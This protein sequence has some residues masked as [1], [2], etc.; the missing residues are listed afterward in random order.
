MAHGSYL[1]KLDLAVFRISDMRSVCLFK[2]FKTYRAVLSIVPIVTYFRAIDVYRADIV[3]YRISQRGP[4]DMS[5]AKYKN[6]GGHTR[7]I[8]FCLIIKYPKT[9][10]RGMPPFPRPLMAQTGLW[11]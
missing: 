7:E 9:G 3:P 5:H 1:A 10:K 11:V 8:I 2:Y 6:Y 4:T